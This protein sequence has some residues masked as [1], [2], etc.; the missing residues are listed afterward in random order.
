MTIYTVGDIH[1]QL[2]ML[3]TAHDHIESDRAREGTAK[4]EVVFIGDYCDRGPDTKGVLNWLVSAVG[5]GANFICLA[6]NHDHMM[7]GF[8]DPT[9]ELDS[10]TKDFDWLADNLGGKSTLKSYGVD[11]R[12]W[13]NRAKTRAT[14]AQAVPQAHV[15]F[16]RS[17]PL[18][19]R[20]PG[21]FF[22]H[23]GID[24]DRPLHDQATEDLLWMR[25]PFLKDT[26]RHDAVIVHGHTPKRDVENTGNRINVDTG[27][28][29]GRPISAVA[30]EGGKVYRLTPEG[31]VRV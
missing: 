3:K 11:I 6:G 29:F 9:F 25:E 14:A 19:H 13:H 2:D 24:P 17:L 23:A 10:K 5:S 30:I 26:R 31:R 16:L 22:C 1:G 4:A 7:L 12:F 21:L 20:A 18:T 28:G 8:V 27:A 15:D